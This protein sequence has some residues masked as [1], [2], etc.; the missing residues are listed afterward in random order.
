MRQLAWRDSRARLIRDL[1]AY[2]VE[3]LAVG[4]VYFV[5]AKVGLT[6]A[7]L[8]PGASAIWPATGFAL[9]STLVRGYR[10]GPAILVA[11][12]AAN[13]TNAGSVYTSAA[14]AAGNMLEALAAAWLINLWSNGRETFETPTDV[15]KFALICL[16]PSTIISATLGVGS[17]TLAGYADPSAFA[18]IWMTWWIGDAAGA[19]VFAPFVVLWATIDPQSFGRS[20]LRATGAVVVAAIAVGV[21]AYSPLIGQTT[22]RDALGFLAILPLMWA[23]LRC[24]QRATATVAVIL[25][26]FALWGTLAGGGPFA[27][28]SLNDSFL[29]L[30]MFLISISVPGL[31]LSADVA[32]R[33][34]SEENLGTAQS[35][36]GL[37]S[38]Q[39]RD[40]TA[41][42]E[43]VLSTIIARAV[44]L[45]DTEAG[46]IY[47]RE[48]SSQKLQLHATYGMSDAMIAAISG[49]AVDDNA[50]VSR[51]FTEREAVQIPDLLDT[52]LSALRN[53][54]LSAGFRAILVVPLLR[55]DEFVGVLVIRRKQPGLF[56]KRTVE[57]LQTLANH[58]VLAIHNAR[59]FSGIEEKSRQLAIAN[60]SKSRFMA[61]ANH[62][63]R[64]PLHA[65]GLFVEQLRGRVSAVERRQLV[66]RMDAA[67]TAMDE[68]F[69]ALLDISKLDL[70][71]LVPNISEFSIADVLK[72]IDSTFSGAAD[73][74]G[75]ALRTVPSSSWVRSD[76]I[77]LER[78]LLNLVSNAVRYT[79][80]GG[81]VVGCRRQGG[82]LRIEVWDSGAGIPDDQRQNIFAEF[83]RLAASETDHH[84]G[85]GLGLAIV[86]RLC[87][88]L[89]HPIELKSMVGKGSCF[90]VTVSVATA[91]ARTV[92]VPD[93]RE[94]RF[95]AFKDKLI[96]VIDDDAMVLGSTGGLLR[97]WG[98]RVV[99][100]GSAD[101]ALAGLAE[102]DCAPDLI[103]SD[104]HLSDGETGME[105]IAHLRAA[106]NTSIP[107]FLISGDTGVEPLRAARV[108]RYHLLRK[109]VRPMALRNMLHRYLRGHDVADASTRRELADFIG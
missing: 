93:S 55:P 75:I 90:A 67:V 2:V 73:K 66:E 108:A 83:C 65:L 102:Y 78:I 18:S 44:Q 85:L 99:T 53:A 68:L 21:V 36:L 39:L 10:V 74:K 76:P 63:L 56:P 94:P 22:Y 6:L 29:L 34:R 47:V 58:S 81:V 11:S 60:I 80:R 105:A 40:A 37:I 49:I 69:D 101:A 16:V 1:A 96:V 54:I 31:A 88:L 104:Y 64:Q 3:L 8:N 62:D 92:E 70:G 28:D 71:V 95:D 30:I 17:L 48:E 109:P 35:E 15:A 72:R 61:V 86:D 84:A 50:A 43:T 79:T 4:T 98:C 82:F 38:T 33:R 20:Q 91:P 100:A 59:L 41:D 12:F 19:L 26:C 87:R 57:L 14:I 51:A 25:S 77:L 42:L 106:L 27:R 9:A 23:A 32:M 7:S 46:A 45:S 5:L 107:A 13:V 97:R 52:P 103:I 24:D 89:E